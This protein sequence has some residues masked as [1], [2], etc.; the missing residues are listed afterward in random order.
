M[1]IKWQ[2]K[3]IIMADARGRL[4]GRQARSRPKAVKSGRISEQ[5]EAGLIQKY[6]RLKEEIK[7][8]EGALVAFSGGID[9]SLLLRVATDVLGK[10]VTAVIV[11]TPLFSRQ[12]IQA[13][14]RLAADLKVNLITVQI[15]S[16]EIPGVAKNTDKRCYYCKFTLF[17]RLKELAREMGLN[18]VLEGSNLDDSADF[19]P[20]REALKELGIYSPLAEAGLTKAEIR[21]LARYLG[22]SNWNKPQAACL[23]SRIPYGQPL[24][25]AILEKIEKGEEIIRQQGFSQV[26]LRHHGEIARIEIDPKEFPLWLKPGISEKVVANLKKLGYRYV[27]LDL[28]GY[29]TGSLNPTNR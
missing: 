8:A 24:D 13:A 11:D 28:D 25:R 10:R 6:E 26:R 19:R 23:A 16:L 2:K 9:S 12:E 18:R 15:D 1:K 29:R 3:G 5:L 20:G 17:S 21:R 4:R 27:T 14:R 22:L 7:S